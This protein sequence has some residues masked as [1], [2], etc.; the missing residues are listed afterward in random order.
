M[1]KQHVFSS[2][3][4]R[5]ISPR[6]DLRQRSPGTKLGEP[7]ESEGPSVSLGLGPAGEGG[8]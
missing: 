4:K 5:A 7:L 2:L 3:H 6:G 8:A 1:R